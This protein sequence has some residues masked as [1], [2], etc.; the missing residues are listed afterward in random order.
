MLG[1]RDG[2]VK[3]VPSLYRFVRFLLP[4]GI[5][6]L[7]L[8]GATPA[9]A[10]TA[11]VLPCR[12]D[13]PC[14]PPPF[15]GPRYFPQTGFRIEQDAF[16]DYFQR[17]G[18]VPTFG[19]P[20]SRTFTL[21]GYPTQFFQRQVMQLWPDGSVH[22]LNLLDPGMLPYTTFNYSTFPAL[23]PQLVAAAPTPTDPNY[24]SDTLSFVRAHAPNSWNGLPVAFAQAYFGTVTPA[25]AFPGQAASSPQVQALL[26]LVQLEVWGLPTSAPAYDPTNH[27]FVY[28]R[29]QRGILMFD[30]GCG[31]TQAVLFG[32]YLK[33]VIEDEN[34][35]ADLA[36]EAS[37]S[38]YFAQ[39]APSQP[40]WLARPAQLPNTNLTAA[41]TRPPLP[42]VSGG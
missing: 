5:A 16:W 35:P 41:F 11:P 33:A 31:C 7:V 2:R 17:R 6:T 13:F 22:L 37:G 24:G 19:Y 28:L 42:L 39:Y 21:L 12:V 14:P 15:G 3:G 36:A 26:P 23:D 38:A 25:A 18:G 4:L 32:D 29:L 27:N 20:T 34:L 40:N 1:I 8:I 10:A 9:L 30:A